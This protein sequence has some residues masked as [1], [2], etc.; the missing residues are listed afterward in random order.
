MVLQWTPINKTRGQNQERARLGE[1]LYDSSTEAS[2]GD[3]SND[4]SMSYE[5]GASDGPHASDYDDNNVNNVMRRGRHIR[6][7]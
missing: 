1:S 2:T 6:P 7:W 3:I 4:A 5:E